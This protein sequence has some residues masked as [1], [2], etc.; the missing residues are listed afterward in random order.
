MKTLKQLS[1]NKNLE[2]L[3]D[4]VDGWYKRF[5]QFCQEHPRRILRTRKLWDMVHLTD[6]GHNAR[7]RYLYLKDNK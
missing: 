3:T 6:V 4:E 5:M 2:N 7:L 1:D